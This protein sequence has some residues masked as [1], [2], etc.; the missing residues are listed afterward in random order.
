VEVLARS[1]LGCALEGAGPAKEKGIGT[2]M[3]SRPTSVT[4]PF[5]AA[6]WARSFCRPS[7]CSGRY[8]L[9]GPPNHAELVL[10]RLGLLGKVGAVLPQGLDCVR[11]FPARWLA[12]AT[13]RKCFSL[14]K[15]RSMRFP[16]F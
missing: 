14:L 8:P 1:D 10:V 7:P 11:T 15:Q 3:P 13:E 2:E 6:G 12:I 9:S 5:L 4:A 16:D